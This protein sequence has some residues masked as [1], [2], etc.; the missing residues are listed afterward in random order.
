MTILACSQRKVR[1]V[2][3]VSSLSR[4]TPRKRFKWDL[5][6]KMLL[7]VRRRLR[8]LKNLEGVTGAKRKEAWGDS[9]A[10]YQWTLP[11]LSREKSRPSFPK[12]TWKNLLTR[13]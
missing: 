11:T 8:R 12:R 1:K 7:S 13:I 4:R 3:G 6:R 9:P 10:A 5:R 2:L